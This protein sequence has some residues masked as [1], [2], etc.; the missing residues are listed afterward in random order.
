MVGLIER[1][2]FGQ[3][4][5]KVTLTPIPPSTKPSGATKTPIS[6]EDKTAKIPTIKDHTIEITN[7]KYH[8][9]EFTNT[10]TIVF[11]HDINQSIGMERQLS[12]SIKPEY[13]IKIR[14]ELLVWVTPDKYKKLSELGYKHISDQYKGLMRLETTSEIKKGSSLGIRFGAE[15]QLTIEQIYPRMF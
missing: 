1:I 7:G 11:V 8:Y 14:I 13:D 10:Y 4:E 3:P 15:I 6:L 5:T 12:V 9:H 2:L